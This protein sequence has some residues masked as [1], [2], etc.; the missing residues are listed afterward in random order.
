MHAPHEHAKHL[1]DALS[2]TTMP[3]RGDLHREG[4]LRVVVTSHREPTEAVALC[5]AILVL[6]PKLLELDEGLVVVAFL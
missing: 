5:A 3:R 4:G 1:E 6:R 2:A